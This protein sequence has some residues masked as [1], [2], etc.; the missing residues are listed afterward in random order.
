MNTWH[1]VGVYKWLR[2]YGNYGVYFGLIW[3]IG[4]RVEKEGPY[5]VYRCVIVYNV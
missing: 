2:A 4:V 3:F 1:E 5:K